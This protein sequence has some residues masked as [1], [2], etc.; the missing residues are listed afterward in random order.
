ME[1]YATALTWAIPFFVSLILIEAIVDRYF[2]KVGVN[3]GMDTVSS[4]SSGMTNTLKE[5]IGLSIVIVSYGWMVDHFAL[6]QFDSTLL[7]FVLCFIGI[8]FASYWSHRFNHEINLFWN[9]H[10]VHHSSEEFNLACALRQSISSIVGIYFFLYIPLA[11][12]G[13]PTNIIA[14]VAP[15]H[16][17]AQFWY[18]T[19]L[20]DRMGF[21][22][23]LIVTPSHHR[24]HHAIN[25]EYVD[26]NYAAVFIV[27][28][29]WFGTFQ[30]EQPDI[31]P[32]YGTLKPSN[33]WNPILIN[34]MHLWAIIQDAWRTRSWW[35]KIRVWFMPTG[36]R[37]EDV[38]EKYPRTGIEKV[39]EQVK[40]NP[41]ASK[42][43]L[44]WSWFQLLFHNFLIYYVLYNFSLVSYPEMI[45]F[46]ALLFISIFAY[47][48][49]MD[50]HWIAVPVEGLKFLFALS[51][52]YYFEGWMQ[53]DTFLQGATW[54]MLAYFGFSFALTCYISYVEQGNFR[55]KQDLVKI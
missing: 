42:L 5:L 43:L 51:F 2:M 17:F 11:I 1:A 37:P 54:L 44:Y 15:L 48:S 27:W 6:F 24:V 12:L 26:K 38:K 55:A 22:E 39:Y 13:I 40:Y 34:Y 45:A 25:P 20:I 7:L 30:E 41:S 8:D 10:I 28:D 33:T 49:L 32:V 50:R 14:V 18:H 29:K 16:L 9:R 19:R 35:D 4:L 21:L 53:M 47:T 36:W 3:N 23:H 31:P 46:V 52:I